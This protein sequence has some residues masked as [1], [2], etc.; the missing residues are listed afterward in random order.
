MIPPSHDPC[1]TTLEER[2]QGVRASSDGCTEGKW[3]LSWKL[4]T[5]TFQFAATSWP[6]RKMRVSAGPARASHGGPP[7]QLSSSAGA[8]GSRFTNTTP[9]RVST[10]GRCRPGASAAGRPPG[11]ANTRPSV[12]YV[13]PW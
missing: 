2:A 10:R 1:A 3:W 8:S 4:P 5:S 11:A 12:A 13:Q 7:F 6:A 9:A